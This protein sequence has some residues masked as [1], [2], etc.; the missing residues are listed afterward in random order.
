MAN[1]IKMTGNTKLKTLKQEFTSK[2]PYVSFGVA[3]EDGK[4]IKDSETIATARTK[5]S[6]DDLSIVGHLGAGTLKKR[7]K[8]TYGIN[9]R[10]AFG[11]KAGKGITWT[12]TTDVTTADLD[13]LTLSELNDWAKKNG[14]VELTDHI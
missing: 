4:N 3:T 8:D 9:A 1:E 5:A 6:K 11:K 7:F 10:V 12:L 14:Y 13:K 2:F